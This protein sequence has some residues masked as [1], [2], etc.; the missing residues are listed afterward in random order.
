MKTTVIA[1]AIV[2]MFGGF[3]NA[4]AA[5]TKIDEIPL[6]TSGSHHG[7]AFDGEFWL[8]AD[9]DDGF[10]RYNSN[11][12]AV[13]STTV[14][15]FIDM[16]G[17]TF[18]PNS[19]NLFLGDN[20]LSFVRQV[21][22]SGAT[23]GQFATTTNTLNPLAYDGQSDTIW[24]GYCDGNIEN[25]TLAGSLLSSFSIDDCWTGLAYDDFNNT[26]LGL[27]HGND[28]V[29]HEFE[30]DGTPLGQQSLFG[31]I[32]DNPQG[33]AYD[34]STGSLYVTSQI[35]GRVTIF[36]DASRTIPEP[37]TCTL[38]LAALCLAMSRRR[39]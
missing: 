37:T 27:S 24:L 4:F 10:N 38:A 18:N 25:R 33:I 19:G 14:P 2:F 9:T 34:S 21:T 23:V 26:L 6:T 36:Q 3:G 5:F 35:P 16:R 32:Q 29:L 13:G 17:L 1:T 20:D 28:L 11:F 30:T 7:I 22:L 31:Q 12:T 15:G 39:V 8:I